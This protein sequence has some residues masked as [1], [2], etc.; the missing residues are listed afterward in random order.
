MTLRRKLSAEEQAEVEKHE[1]QA[2][3]AYKQ[4]ETVAR[5]KTTFSVD[6]LQSKLPLRFPCMVPEVPTFRCLSWYR[7]PGWTALCDDKQ[8]EVESAFYIALHVVDFAPLRAELV[9]LTGISLDAPGQTPFD[10]VSLFLC[11]L[12]RW[13]KGL[14]WKELAKLLVREEGACW[15]RLFGFRDDCLPGASTMRTFYNKLD[16][17]F[18]GDLSPRFIELIYFCLYALYIANDPITKNINGLIISFVPPEG[19]VGG[20]RKG[21]GIAPGKLKHTNFFMKYG[22][23]FNMACESKSKN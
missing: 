16:T 4:R 22:R 23:F 2:K 15:R 11:C 5:F 12:L 7:Y 6:A 9:A 1:R 3:T 8:L 17:L 14:G 20:S 13:E 19:F 18:D 21:N 10:P